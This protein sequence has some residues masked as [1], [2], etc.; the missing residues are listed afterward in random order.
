MRLEIHAKAC[1]RIRW[2]SMLQIIRT[3]VLAYF[4]NGIFGK[5]LEYATHTHRVEFLQVLLSS[6]AMQVAKRLVHT[7]T[8]ASN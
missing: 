2:T 5:Q 6:P 8:E 1:I 7:R 3:R 4:Q